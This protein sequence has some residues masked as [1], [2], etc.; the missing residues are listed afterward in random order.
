MS[1]QAVAETAPATGEANAD[2]TSGAGDAVAEDKPLFERSEMEFFE[3]EDVRAGRALGKMLSLFFLYTILAM[4]LAA[5]WTWESIF[6]RGDDSPAET[7]A[8]N[9]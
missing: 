9:H 7:S 3:S 8:P 1:E 2:T 4:S 6:E 5:Y